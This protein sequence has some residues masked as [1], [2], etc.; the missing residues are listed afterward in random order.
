MRIRR[1]EQRLQ[2]AALNV[3]RRQHELRRQLAPP[4]QPC[5]HACGV[6]EGAED[7]VALD[8]AAGLPCRQR[9]DAEHPERRRPSLADRPQE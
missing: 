4:P 7:G 5:Q 9:Q 8:A 3:G 2:R 6:G 1:V